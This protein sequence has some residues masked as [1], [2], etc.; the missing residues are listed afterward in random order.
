VPPLVALPTGAIQARVQGI[1]ADI[2]LQ[3]FSLEEDEEKLTA[4][5]V[6]PMTIN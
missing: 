3:D 4:V 6:Q 2:D 1:A 5:A